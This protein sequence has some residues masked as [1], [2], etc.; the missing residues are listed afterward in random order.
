M[1]DAIEEQDLTEE[2]GG[3]IFISFS[4]KIRANG[5]GATHWEQKANLIGI[6]LFIFRNIPCVTGQSMAFRKPLLICS[7]SSSVRRFG[8]R[9]ALYRYGRP[10]W[11]WAIICRPRSIASVTATAGERGRCESGGRGEIGFGDAAEEGD[12]WMEVEGSAGV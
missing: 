10:M 12:G 3:R 4:A 6:Q 8:I 9:S 7:R 5:I 2:S 11:N 1:R